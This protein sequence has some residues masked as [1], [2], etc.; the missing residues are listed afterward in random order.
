[1]EW[2]E[3]LFRKYADEIA[4]WKGQPQYLKEALERDREEAP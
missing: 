1:M 2:L 4:K 3:E